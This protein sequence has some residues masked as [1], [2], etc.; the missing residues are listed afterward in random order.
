MT[1][2]R[3]RNRGLTRLFDVVVLLCVLLFTPFGSLLERVEAK[4]EKAQSTLLRHI[5]EK[6]H[7]L[8]LWTF[9]DPESKDWMTGA[10]SVSPGTTVTPARLGG[11]RHF[12]G[13]EAT[14]ISTQQKWSH[15]PES[16]SITT[17]INLQPMPVVQDILMSPFNQLSTGITFQYGSLICTAGESIIT[18]PYQNHLHAFTHITL[19]ADAATGLFTVYLNGKQAGQ[20]AYTSYSKRDDNIRFGQS[21]HRTTRYP[22]RGILD[23]TAIFDRA[24][25]PKD[26]ARLARLR[27]EMTTSLASTGDL[28]KTWLLSAEKGLLSALLTAQDCLRGLSPNA[29]RGRRA[30]ARLP[31]VRL[32][33]SGE[34][35]R[36]FIRAHNRSRKSGRRTNSG[37]SP[38]LVHVNL[39]GKVAQVQLCLE[40]TDTAYADTERPSYIL[41]LGDSATLFGTRRL[42]LSAPERMD[43]TRLLMHQ[44]LQQLQGKPSLTNGLCRLSMN[45]RFLGVYLFSDY[46]QNGVLPGELPTLANAG[47]G[48]SL[49]RK[50][51]YSWSDIFKRTPY[52][53]LPEQA[54]ETPLPW[55]AD[56]ASA[57][58]AEAEKDWIPPLL[59]DPQSPLSHTALQ[60]SLQGIHDTVG[61]FWPC[62]DAT[63]PPAQRQ[64]NALTE[65]ALLGTNASPDRLVASLDLASLRLLPGVSLRWR[66]DPQ[67]AAWLAADG[68]V[69]RPEKSG[70]VAASLTAILSD[71]SGFQTEKTLSFRVMP[72]ENPI[73]ALSL[74][75]NDTVARERRVDAIAF[76]FGPNSDTPTRR[77]TA[78]QSTRGG[79][80]HRGNAG[81]IK[82]K[83]PLGISFDSPHEILAQGDPLDSIVTI[84]S[85]QDPSFLNNTVS[86]W[87]F[88]H[89]PATTEPQVTARTRPIE[90]YLN[91]RFHGL[92]EVAEKVDEELLNRTLT[93]AEI[94]ASNPKDATFHW[95][96][97]RFATVNPRIPEML[98]RVPNPRHV[99]TQPTYEALHQLFEEDASP[100]WIAKVQ[101][102]IDL[103]N[104]ADFQ[105]LINL[106]QNLN[107]WPFTFTMM[108]AL[109]YNA[110]TQRFFYV[111]WDFDDC[112]RS[113]Y[114]FRWMQTKSWK[115]LE[116]DL[117][118]YQELLHT[119]WEA[120]KKA[121]ISV[122]SI[123][124][125]MD[126]LA[127]T[128]APYAEWDFK[129]WNYSEGFSYE[130]VLTDRKNAVLFNFESMDRHF[131]EPQN[132][133]E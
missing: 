48:F 102:T 133:V 53:A 29:I 10:P 25:S 60:A 57:L 87:I 79:I 56:E 66:A 42:L 65:F 127:A 119:R 14:F 15:I 85:Q 40:G 9:S 83:I 8:H 109:V 78:T 88:R 131:T 44:H 47:R 99:D 34:D 132:V 62:A 71:P 106:A 120:L 27:R 77:L 114:G 80:K 13:R 75:V 110:K 64:A 49:A 108:E 81:Y 89:F 16:F 3:R 74:Y 95:A 96:V 94:A 17:W 67:S 93:H 129:R 33:L 70:P 97:Y 38:K 21:Y 104:T 68:T 118:G 26:V 63:T 101:Q 37:A 46:A 2:Q 112:F 130:E 121:G 82:S 73:P 19:T 61:S 91:G 11:G 1:A 24:L 58:L 31:E 69:T 76:W 5:R 100:E 12:D 51:S 4:A 35:R 123:H 124:A 90:I 39:G 128:L 20:T 59:Y 111:P 50:A 43:W 18:L 55:T 105:L 23:D 32:F 41:E 52:P 28:T 122:E 30:I 36:H 45:G 107:G 92:F 54:R 7:L 117:P 116:E 84:N 115:R 22:M 103:E 98:Q 126:E 86:A 125:K 113:K 72:K 6:E